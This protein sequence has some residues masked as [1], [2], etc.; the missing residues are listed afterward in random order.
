M[1]IGIVGLGTVGTAMYEW[2]KKNA[3]H[4]FRIV[5]PIKGNH[6]FLNDCDAVFVSIPVPPGEFGQ[7]ISTLVR[8]TREAR[9]YTKNV[10]IRST[11][12]PGTS[13]VLHCTAMP[14][15]L[16]QRR[17]PEDFEK[18]PIVVGD[19]DFDLKQVFPGKEIIKTTNRT[20]E[21]AKF[22]HNCFGA[23]KVTYWNIISEMCQKTNVSYDQLLEVA[24]ITGFIG[25]EHLK[26]PGPDGKKGW[27]GKCFPENMKAME[28]FLKM[29]TLTEESELFSLIQKINSIHRNGSSTFKINETH[30][31]WD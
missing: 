29:I 10:F 21:L 5:D 2:L 19:T 23:F 15:F 9:Q 3:N 13:D 12:I 17:A 31:D 6:D 16:T 30:Y 8:V 18:L 25:T 20:A 7:D 11:I 27:G 24:K 1:I 22:A 14:E 4:Q 26:V 28:K